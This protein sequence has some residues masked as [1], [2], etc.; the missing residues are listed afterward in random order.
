MASPYQTG[1][2]SDQGLQS[3]IGSP[4]YSFLQSQLY[5]SNSQYEQGEKEV[6][7]DYSSVLNQPTLGDAAAERKQQYIQQVQQGLKKVATTD[8]S[9]PQNVQQA[10]SLYA[11]FWQDSDLLQNIAGTK[12]IQNNQQKALSI[13]NSADEKIRDTFDQRYLD[14]LKYQTNNLANAPLSENKN[15]EITDWTPFTKVIDHLDKRKDADKFG[16]T[17]D[18][19]DGNGNII[20]QTNG[21]NSLPAFKNYADAQLGS[22][23]EAQ[24]RVLGKLAKEQQIAHYQEIHP[25][26]TR[27]QASVAA[28][29]ELHD[30]L[31]KT[32]KQRD[33]E[34]TFNI[35]SQQTLLDGIN[36]Q[37]AGNPG[38]IPSPTQAYNKKRYEEQIEDLG[39]RQKQIQD[40]LKKMD[41]PDGFQTTIK[42]PEEALAQMQRTNDINKWA[43]AESRK[44]VQSIKKDESYWTKQTLNK[45]Y[46][47]LG[48]THRHNTEDEKI[49]QYNAVSGRMNAETAAT[50]LKLENPFAFDA[51][52]NLVANPIGATPGGA[53]I[54][55]LF[56]M[57]AVDAAD[58][59]RT[60]LK[61]KVVSSV[62]GDNGLASMIT[63][64]I[65]ETQ[66]T[67]DDVNGFRQVMSKFMHGEISQDKKADGTYEYKG[68]S[69][70]ERQ[71]YG[72]MVDYL[73]SLKKGYNLNSL[74][75]VHKAF[76]QYIGDQVNTQQSTGA[77]SKADYEKFKST[78]KT[79][80][81]YNTL[82]ENDNLQREHLV[83]ESINSKSSPNYM[84]PAVTYRDTDGRVKEVTPEVIN[85]LAPYPE[86]QVTGTDGEKRTYTPIQLAT[87][88]TQGK[89][90]SDRIDYTKNTV[91]IDGK[92]YKVDAI[93]GKPYHYST[94]SQNGQVYAN[95]NDNG[96]HTFWNMIHGSGP[97]AG[98]QVHPHSTIGMFGTSEGFKA[99]YQNLY[100]NIVPQTTLGKDVGK[101]GE[102]FN[103]PHAPGTP[104]AK[105]LNEDL[106]PGQFR[107]MYDVDNKDKPIDDN[108]QKAVVQI[109]NTKDLSDLIGVSHRYV[110][111][112]FNNTKGVIL[113]FGDLSGTDV[114]SLP[115]GY[116]QLSNKKIFVEFSPTHGAFYNNYYPSTEDNSWH[117]LN[118]PGGKIQSDPTE[119]KLL[120]GDYK[121]SNSGNTYSIQGHV[122]IFNSQTGKST[123]QRVNLPLDKSEHS[124]EHATQQARDYWYNQASKYMSDS[125]T[126]ANKQQL[127]TSN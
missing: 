114:K 47:V 94:Y 127:Q 10:E 17:F 23:L 2:T 9:L 26:T 112:S 58:A 12:R 124:P 110:T 69:S 86:I 67:T 100:K 87:L 99:D 73:G 28:F 81:D 89:I 109:A 19:A 103:V 63:L 57:N 34:Y 68:M 8:L 50:K 13:Q 61:D 15:I 123:L 33:D 29:G 51:N 55:E 24:Y 92:E 88:H 78:Y 82:Y 18:F 97:G 21:I 106:Q 107:T 98:Y 30:G 52:G 93:D 1:P 71:E 4:D 84:A 126:Y 117:P 6:V 90:P 43:D 64:Q 31:L 36:K 27:E 5:R 41:T 102:S 96:T 72:K 119:D 120:G 91:T 80:K 105:A 56:H 83:K 45:D 77:M 121:I 101:V 111:K 95:E 62:Y 75:D 54:D 108:L 70:T 115:A 53:A 125:T 7:A 46:A 32:Y 44:E 38:Q 20:T 74:D 113:S 118:Q 35:S 11:P 14:L 39:N 25:G 122:R 40:S 65:P 49:G 37:I 76:L 16:V 22:D 59:K 85:K 3:P 66:A 79:M 104:G 42:Y 48:E 116:K 60:I